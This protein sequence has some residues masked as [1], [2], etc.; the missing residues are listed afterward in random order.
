MFLPRARRGAVALAA[1]A[2]VAVYVVAGTLKLGALSNNPAVL[3]TWGLLAS[4]AVLGTSLLLPGR[5]EA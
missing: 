2:A 4:W 1:A 5:R 3:A